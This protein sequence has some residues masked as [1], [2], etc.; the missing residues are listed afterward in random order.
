MLLKYEMELHLPVLCLSFLV[1]TVCNILDVTNFSYHAG[2]ML[3][4][5]ASLAIMLE[6]ILIGIQA[7]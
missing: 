7:L 5:F 2:I 1:C 3:D 6:T 4:A